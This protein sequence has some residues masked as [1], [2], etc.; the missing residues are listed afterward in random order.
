MEEIIKE[1]REK[2]VGGSGRVYSGTL[3]AR[4]IEKFWLSK[5]KE[6]CEDLSKKVEEKYVASTNPNVV[7]GY[8]IKKQE[9]LE[10]LKKYVI[11]SRV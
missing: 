6:Q 11:L 8:E 2:F 5:Q 3:T 9:V 4:K 10:L 1:F 7:K